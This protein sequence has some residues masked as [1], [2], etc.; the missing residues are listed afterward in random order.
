MTRRKRRKF[1][2]TTTENGLVFFP[3]S[4]SFGGASGVRGNDGFRIC[5][6]HCLVLSG[7]AD[8]VLPGDTDF[9][10]GNMDGLVSGF[11]SDRGFR[12][13]HLPAGC[14]LDGI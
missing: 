13:L 9:W 5:H 14:G 11:V 4:G 10:Q 1:P 8:G 6:N 12:R 2:S 7:A 3:V